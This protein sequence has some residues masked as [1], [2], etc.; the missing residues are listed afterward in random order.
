MA[1]LQTNLDG[2]EP[3]ISIWNLYQSA[4]EPHGGFIGDGRLLRYEVAE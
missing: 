4:D 1:A 3:R 2:L